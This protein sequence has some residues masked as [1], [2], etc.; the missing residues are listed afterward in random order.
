M[1]LVYK[2]CTTTKGLTIVT[3]LSREFLSFKLYWVL[4][5]YATERLLF[6]ND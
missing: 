1:E 4:S 3:R 2:Y 5:L 6:I